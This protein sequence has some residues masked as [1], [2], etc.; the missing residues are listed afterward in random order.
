MGLPNLGNPT[1]ILLAQMYTSDHRTWGRSFV[2]TLDINRIESKPFHALPSVQVISHSWSSRYSKSMRP[3]RIFADQFKWELD[4]ARLGSGVCHVHPF[5]PS[6]S[7]TATTRPAFGHIIWAAAAI[8]G[9]D[10]SHSSSSL[11]IV[12]TLIWYA[13]DHGYIDQHFSRVF[14]G[15]LADENAL[16]KTRS[17]RPGLLSSIVFYCLLLNRVLH[18]KE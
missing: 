6:P 2:Q 8:P 7:D 10:I 4:Q 9:F 11:V 13:T 16:A 18:P 5:T 17:I 12:T 1:Q 3:T 15:F 14:A